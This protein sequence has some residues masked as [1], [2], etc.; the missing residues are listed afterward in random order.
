MAQINVERKQNKNWWIWV[1]IVIAILLAWLFMRNNNEM[2]PISPMSD[3][4]IIEDTV[5]PMLDTA[6][7]NDTMMNDTIY[8]IPE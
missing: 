7:R 6:I 3:S 4:V 2:D 5:T 1:I 8:P